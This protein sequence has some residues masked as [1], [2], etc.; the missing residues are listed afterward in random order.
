MLC[1]P[2]KT[3]K[4]I[5]D[6][7]HEYVAQVKNNTKELSKWVEFNSSIPNNSI[8]SHQTCDNNTHG[9][10]EQR[11]IEIFDDLY[12]IDS[13]W[14]NIQRIIKLTSTTTIQ[15]KTTQETHYY[16]SSLTVDAITFAK[17]IRSHW[18]IENSLHYIKDVSFEEDSCRTRTEQIPLIQTILRTLAINTFN[19][20]GF[21]NLKQTRKLLAWDNHKLFSLRSFFGGGKS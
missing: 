5:V 16:I 7:G 18:S 20:N 15:S 10:H 17:I 19:L 2:K 8:D 13:T 14:Q 3:L 4:K 6:K 11:H 1:I 21:T 9:R 12:G